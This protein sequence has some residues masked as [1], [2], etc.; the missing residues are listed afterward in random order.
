MIP[1]RSYFHFHIVNFFPHNSENSNFHLK[2][3]WLKVF[4]INLENPAFLI[5]VCLEEFSPV[6]VLLMDD[7]R[8]K[9]ENNKK[10]GKIQ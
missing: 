8:L 7:K 9:A 1:F 10:L 4:P 3:R 6:E 2:N 5:S